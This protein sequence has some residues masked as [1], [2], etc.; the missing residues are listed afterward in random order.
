M[1]S[2]RNHSLALLA[3]TAITASA[4]FA[5]TVDFETIPGQTPA[6][7]VVISDQYLVS[8][9][10]SFSL[11]NGFSPMLVEIGGNT[12][13]GFLG[14]QG[15]VFNGANDNPAPGQSVGNFYLADNNA[16]E[17][18]GPSALIVSFAAP[19]ARAG[20]VVLDIDS[21][22]SILIEA[23]DASDALLDSIVLAAG[24][25]GT[26][27]GIATGFGFSYLNDII[28]SLRISYT[29]QSL[30]AGYVVDNFYSEQAEI[31]VDANNNPT[32]IP[33]PAAVWSILGTLGG[34]G[35]VRGVK[36]KRRSI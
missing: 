25:P 8:Q 9:G 4:S 3:A 15:A 29:G 5:G 23:F 32:A 14:P 26:G 18:T 30:W 13:G 16:I 19:V 6:E 28:A 11:E 7:G 10:M 21:Q 2:I 36:R 34:L 31:L 33:L 12:I 35:A 20:G 24:A 22:E 17:M 27:D 1:K